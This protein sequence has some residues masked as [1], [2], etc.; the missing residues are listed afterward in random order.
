MKFE[1][2]SEELK[3]IDDW[4]KKLPKSEVGAIGGRLEY[5]F[6][7]TSLGVVVKVKDCIT[8]TELDLTEYESW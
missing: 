2:S 7:P 4:V 6:T 3:K 1:L 5:S 8:K